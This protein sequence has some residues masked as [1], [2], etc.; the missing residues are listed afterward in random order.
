MGI[1]GHL[2]R[3]LSR[4]AAWLDAPVRVLEPDAAYALWA[5]DYPASAHNPLMKTEQ[6]AMCQL[7][8]PD[9][10]GKAVVDAGCGSGRYIVEAS[11]RGA[12]RVVGVD[13]SA[14][15]LARAAQVSRNV[16]RAD[17]RALPLR[18]RWSDLTICGLTV[19]HLDSLTGALAELCRVTRPGGTILCSDFHPI[20][21]TIGGKRDFSV[22]GRRYAARHTQHLYGAWHDA[23]ASLGLRITR[24][25]EPSLDPAD[26]PAGSRMVVAHPLVIVFE[27]RR[28]G[29]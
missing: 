20:A 8:P 29:N 27:V 14:A 24:V 6:R 19:G 3:A 22:D 10:R 11:S 18:D 5:K 16:V 26:L 2:I 9:L 25:L 1:R 28:E 12:A 13:L 23:C 17:L 15:M 7:L 21:H 4:A